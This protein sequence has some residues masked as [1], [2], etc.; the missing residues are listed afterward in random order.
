M[1][2]QILFNFAEN[3]LLKLGSSALQQIGLA[4]GVTKELEKL[5]NT[6]STVRNVLLDAQEQ[7]ISNRAVKE[8]LE[9]LNDIVYDVDDLVDEFATDALRRE[10]EIHGSIIR[11]VRYFFTRSNPFKFRY[12][13][14]RKIRDVRERLDEVAKDMR[15]FKFVVRRVDRPIERRVREET[16][17]FPSSKIVGRENDKEAIIQLLM[18]STDEENVSIIPIVGLGGLGKTTLAQLVYNDDRVQS[19]FQE[20]LWVC[21]S[22]DFDLRKV[23]EKIVKSVGDT[24]SDNLKIEQLQSRLRQILGNKK[25]FLVLDDVW[26]EDLVK[27]RNFKD[28][29][30]VGGK[31]SKIIVT[32]RSEKVAEIMGTDPSYVLKGLSN[33]DSLSVLLK[34]AFKQGDE[35]KHQDLVNIGREIV[36]KCGGVP[37]AARTLGALLFSKIDVHYWLQ[38]RD[39]EIWELVQKDYD[40]LPVLKLSYDQ[41]SFY[42]KHC[43]AHLSLIEKDGVFSKHVIIYLWMALGFIESSNQNEELEDIGES[44][45]NELV[46]RSFIEVAEEEE[47]FKMHDLV[48]DLAQFVAA[49][50]CLTIKSTT[51]SIPE[52]VRHVNFDSSL[53]E[54]FPRPL[55][56]VPSSIGDIKHLRLFGLVRNRGA[57]TL[58]ESFGRLVNL[59]YVDLRGTYLN[60]WPKTFVNLRFLGLSTRLTSLPEKVIGRLTSLRTLIICNSYELTSLTEAMGK[61]TRL[62]TLAVANCPKLVSF[63]S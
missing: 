32:T 37:L 61:I 49:S 9:R 57:K 24:G 62:R 27:W 55:L 54:E 8:W 15:D 21:V 60:E 22:N 14:G 45:F 35:E 36:K 20:T 31:G 47:E 19:Q 3:I 10:V 34:W 13:M 58:P 11:E 53:H 33:D 28:L 42:L 2:E 1:A 38:V 17:S 29:L 46:R 39:N 25:I 40:I 59:Q 51:K 18:H 5:G 30:M 48:H 44:Y 12:G 4:W 41:M 63:P 43:F 26:N 52:R 7:Q 6:I 56:E 50:E 23:I 16:Y